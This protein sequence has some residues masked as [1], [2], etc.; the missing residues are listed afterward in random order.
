M[1]VLLISGTADLYGANRIFLQVI[2]TLYPRNIVLV[3]PSQGPLTDVIN[4]MAYNNITILIEKDIPVI[5]RSMNSI[6]GIT[7]VGTKMIR[8][9]SK[10]RKIIDKYSINWAYVNTLSCILP[11]KLMARIKIKT[12][13]HVHEM[14]ENNKFLTKYIN[15]YSCLWPTRII[16]VSKP[17]KENLLL[18]GNNSNALAKVVTI[19]N[20]IPDRFNPGMKDTLLN[21]LI[22]ITLLGRIIPGK[23]IWFYLNTI[24]LL[25]PDLVQKCIFQIVGG[26]APGGDHLVDI[27]KKD[28]DNHKF[29]GQIRFIPF[30]RDITKVLNESDIIVVPSLIPDSFPSTLLEGLSA[31]K[32]VIATNTGGAV[33]AIMDGKTGFLINPGDVN[34]FR[35]KLE[36][37]IKNN[38]LRKKMGKAARKDYLER[39]TIERFKKDLLKEILLFEDSLR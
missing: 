21:R 38:E 2:E 33:Q 17:V 9:Q 39:F 15:K 34:T 26:P 3:L 13:L 8:F 19:L 5:G 23:G 18:A 20:G 29:S 28:I 10:L 25:R 4:Q 12:M 14:L 36:E 24:K 35:D 27:L 32:P 16:T 7:G 11:L 31:G 30:I 22:T 37:L 6:S 1:N